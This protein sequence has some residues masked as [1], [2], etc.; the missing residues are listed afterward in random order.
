MAQTTSRYTGSFETRFEQDVARLRDASPGD[1]QAFIQALTE[2][3]D[4]TLTNDFWDITLPNEL[5][6]SAPKSPALL[7][8]IASLNILDA[9]A[10]LST[11]KVRSRLDPAITTVKGIERHHLFPRAYLKSKLGIKDTKQIN[12]IANMALVEWVDNIAI[13]DRAPS[14]YWPSQTAAR[15]L[16]EEVSA[17]QRYWHA[18]PDNWEHLPY[19]DFLRAR[20]QLMAKVVRDAYEQLRS[21]AYSPVY[22]S[23]EVPKVGELYEP[24]SRAHYKVDISDLLEADLL[25]PGHSLFAKVEGTQLIATVLPDGRIAFDGTIYDTPSGASDAAS[26]SSTNGWQFWSASTDDGNIRL[27]ELRERYLTSKS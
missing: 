12:Q 11:G 22:P 17:K 9:D 19:Q 3:L 15:G 6:T 13:S 18:L 16:T 26:A 10:L 5:A 25:T 23:P 2:I 21:P 20:Q 1:A 4:A 8:Y 27:A 24:A 7:A 14:D